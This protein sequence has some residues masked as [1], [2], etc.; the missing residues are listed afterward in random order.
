MQD[1]LETI[2]VLLRILS[3]SLWGAMRRDEA[4]VFEKTNFRV[5]EVGIGTTKKIDDLTDA[6]IASFCQSYSPV[7]IR[8]GVLS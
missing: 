7:S 3:I 6:E 8:S 5:R 2:D 1:D 4:F